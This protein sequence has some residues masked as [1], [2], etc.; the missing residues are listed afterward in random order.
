M[1]GEWTNASSI[2][3]CLVTRDAL[4]EHHVFWQCV[5]CVAVAS[6]LCLCV[7][8]SAC[9]RDR[10]SVFISLVVCL[11][12]RLHCAH[13]CIHA[14]HT[15]ICDTCSCTHAE[16]LVRTRSRTPAGKMFN[17]VCSTL[18]NELNCIL[19]AIEIPDTDGFSRVVLNP[20]RYKI[21]QDN[22]PMVFIIAEDAAGKNKGA[23]IRFIMSPPQ[24]KLEQSITEGKPS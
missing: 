23:I 2:H 21:P 3:V 22:C 12:S 24:K 16:P 4:R 17:A 1:R 19:F 11:Y 20:A 5:F 14:V 6:R 10:A 7:P 13:V 8:D 9:P 18:Y 15:C